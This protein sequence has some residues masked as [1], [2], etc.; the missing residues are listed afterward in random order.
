MRQKFV[1]GNW[2]MYTTAAEAR[3]LAKAIVEG[4][5]M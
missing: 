5:G 4:V 2:K 1:V 3:R